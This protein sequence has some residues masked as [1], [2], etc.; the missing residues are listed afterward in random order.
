MS[1][2]NQTSAVNEAKLCGLHNE[3]EKCCNLNQIICKAE[4]EIRLQKANHTCYS[5]QNW[6]VVSV[7]T[8]W[9][10]SIHHT[11][12]EVFVMMSCMALC[13]GIK[14]KHPAAKKSN[15]KKQL[16]HFQFSCKCTLLYANEVLH[17]INYDYCNTIVCS[18]FRVRGHYP[19]SGFPCVREE[20]WDT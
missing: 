2:L 10:T 11:G 12:W 17:S 19:I 8:L 4:I 9:L 15:E 5:N 14:S 7:C 20:A 1:N 13:M 3:F 18:V 16:V 6:R